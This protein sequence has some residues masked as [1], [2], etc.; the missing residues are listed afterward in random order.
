[1]LAAPQTFRVT[2]AA[3]PLLP[4]EREQ[5]ARLAA[6]VAALLVKEQHRV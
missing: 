5:A 1:M 2:G 6:G 3:G 4:G